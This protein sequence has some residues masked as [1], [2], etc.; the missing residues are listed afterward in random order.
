[1]TTALNSTQDIN[2]RNNFGLVLSGSNYSVSLTKD[3]DTTVTVPSDCAPGI[4]SGHNSNKFL[5]VIV[6]TPSAEVW[7][8]V[9]AT[10]AIP[11]GATLAAVS[12][13]MIPMNGKSIK[14]NA[15]DVLHFITHATSSTANVSVTFYSIV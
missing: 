15:A 7:V 4:T 12:S 13:A 11:V 3:T 10:A 6:V 14:V 8:A 5:A 2:G 9:N 1:M